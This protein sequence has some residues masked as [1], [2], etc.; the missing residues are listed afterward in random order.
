MRGPASRQTRSIADL[1][2]SKRGENR[3][4]QAKPRICFSIWRIRRA[5]WRGKCV[6]TASRAFSRS[7]QSGRETSVSSAITARA[8]NSENLLCS[9]AIPLRESIKRACA[10]TRYCAAVSARDSIAPTKPQIE[11]EKPREIGP[12]DINPTKTISPATTRSSLSR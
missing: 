1:C 8:S 9:I 11:I 4:A 12:R 3:T 7:R 10:I 5:A 2:L 6:S